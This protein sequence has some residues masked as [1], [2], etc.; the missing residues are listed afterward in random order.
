MCSK[1]C[2]RKR[3]YR[4]KRP[5]DHAPTTV[6]LKKNHPFPK[7]NNKNPTQD[8]FP[9]SQRALPP[10]PHYRDTPLLPLVLPILVI[11]ATATTTAT[12]RRRLHHQFQRA[13]RKVPRISF[14][15]TLHPRARDSFPIRRP[16]SSRP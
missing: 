3:W 9:R 8:I 15:R 12:T 14:G 13:N 10:C 2:K 6:S 1:K 7:S 11:T 16:R 4:L 5:A